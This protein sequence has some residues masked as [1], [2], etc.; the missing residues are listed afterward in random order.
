MRSTAAVRE[1]EARL[2]EALAPF[3]A[4]VDR[5]LTIPAVGCTVARVIVAEIG[6]DM[7]RFPTAGAP[8]LV[9]RPLSS[10]TGKCRQAA[11][12]ADA[13]RQPVAQNNAR[14]SRVGGGP[15]AQHVPPRA[16][17][18]SQ[19]SARTQEGDPR[20][21]RLHPDGGVLH[22]ERRRHVPRTRCRLLRAPR[23]SPDH[24]TSHSTPRRARLCPWR[25]GLLRSIDPFLS[26]LAVSASCLCCIR[27]VHEVA[28]RKPTNSNENRQ[29][30]P[31]GT[32]NA[33]GRVSPRHDVRTRTRLQAPAQQPGD[34]RA[35]DSD[36]R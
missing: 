29:R 12:D 13:P 20:R 36:L 35:S 19:E 5:L 28:A 8:G 34:V 22:S 24:P 18:S 7:S 32:P 26:R 21:R 10:P 15:H 23:Q 17:S 9:G 2:G 11:L 14:P 33:T 1:V 30:S 6:F 25:S 16:V 3:Q 27:A 31:Q 4:A